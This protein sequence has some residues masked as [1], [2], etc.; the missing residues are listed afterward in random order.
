MPPTFFAVLMSFVR[1]RTVLGR[2]GV[3]TATAGT[4]SRRFGDF[5][6]F[7]GCC[8]SKRHCSL[9]IW[10]DIFSSGFRTDGVLLPGVDRL[11]CSAPPFST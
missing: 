8:L 11:S 5:G 2:D 9:S 1:L 3:S 4:T 10:F 7:I 6:C